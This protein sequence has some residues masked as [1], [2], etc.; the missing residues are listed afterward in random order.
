MTVE[1]EFSGLN[2]IKSDRIEQ[3]F[4]YFPPSYL[5]AV[6]ILLVFKIILL[7]MCDFLDVMLFHWLWDS[8]ILM[9]HSSFIFRIKWFKLYP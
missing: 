5:F 4:F 7:K 1:T 2:F 8:Y 3:L 9:D 6:Q